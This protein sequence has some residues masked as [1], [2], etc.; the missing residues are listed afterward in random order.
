MVRLFDVSIIVL[1]V[2]LRYIDFGTPGPDGSSTSHRQLF[3]EN[4]FN[5]DVTTNLQVTEMF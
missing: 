3:A 1:S 5:K 4:L 2:D